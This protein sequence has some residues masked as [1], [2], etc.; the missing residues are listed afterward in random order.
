[1]MKDTATEWI[2]LIPQKWS[3]KKIK[4]LLETKFLK[5]VEITYPKELAQKNKPLTE[6]YKWF[7]NNHTTTT[8]KMAYG[9]NQ[10]EIMCRNH[11]LCHGRSPINGNRR[12]A[13]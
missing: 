8:G 5:D 12:I 2:G 6:G 4:Y 3:L 9:Q 11:V 1:M 10:A 7:V 13:V